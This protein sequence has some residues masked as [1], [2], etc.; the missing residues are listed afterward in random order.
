MTYTGARCW[1]KKSSCSAAYFEPRA[2]YYVASRYTNYAVRLVRKPIRCV[3]ICLYR[4]NITWKIRAA[5]THISQVFY[6]LT[7]LSLFCYRNQHVHTCQVVQLCSFIHYTDMIRSLLCPTSGCHTVTIKEIHSSDG[8]KM[9]YCRRPEDG[10]KWPKHVSVMNKNVQLNVF[11]IVHLLVAARKHVY[12]KL[13][14][15]LWGKVR[16]RTNNE[17]TEGE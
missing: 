2:V 8:M 1:E 15:T 10:H 11:V 5:K 12:P 4:T 16:L 14:Y 6:M 17:G 3:T 7:W 9:C 13:Y